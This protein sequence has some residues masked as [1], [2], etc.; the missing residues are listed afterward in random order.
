MGAKKHVVCIHGTWS[1]GPDTW[2]EMA[3]EM[4]KCG[5][6]AH[7]PTLRYHDLPF[8]EG[9]VKMADLSLLD[10]VDDL[11]KYVEE[12]DTPPLLFGI[13]M[14]GLLAQLVAA[15]TPHLGMALFAPAPA[16][17]MFNLYPGTVRVFYNHFMQ[18]GFWKKPLYPEWSA[19]RWGVVNEQ[20]EDKA[21][22]FF[23]TSCAESGKAYAEMALWLLDSGK[24]ASYV[25][26]KAIDT[27]VLVFG[28]GRDRVI[29]H[30]IPR[31][32][33]QRYKNGKYIHLPDSDHLM[34]IGRELPNTMKHIKAWITENDF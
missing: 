20:P 31:V 27:P 13:S 9:A 29:N 24:R 26:V 14:G 21:L 8:L 25:D 32:T 30:R 16:R 17:G 6:Q 33:A 22:E 23:K 15:R 10:Y 1:N 7:A 12:L 34:I 3:P 18:W 4:E 19:F 5:F 2:A 28:G 11:V